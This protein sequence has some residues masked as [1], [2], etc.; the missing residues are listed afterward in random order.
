MSE[1]EQYKGQIIADWKFPEY[2]QHHRSDGW[3]ILFGLV[4]GILLL[5][6]LFTGN[7]LFA[8]IIL[9]FIFIVFVHSTKRPGMVNL[10]IREN[11]IDIEDRHIPYESISAFWIVYKPPYANNL[12]IRRKNFLAPI[13]SIPMQQINPLA[14][15]EILEQHIE[16]DLEE[17][18][19]TL[20]EIL[21]RTLKI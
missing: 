4:S 16:E 19:E 6:A 17:E 15:R 7:F 20:S 12:Y 5:S 11:G 18:D 1:E 9:L 21:S 3:Y 8:V 10:R 2:E 13:L 14:I